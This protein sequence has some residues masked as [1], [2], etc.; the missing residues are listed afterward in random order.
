MGKPHRRV[1]P[2]IHDRMLHTEVAQLFRV[3]P[4]TVQRWAR[5]GRLPAI[6]TPGGQRVFSRAAVEKAYREAQ[7]G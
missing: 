1:M 5:N 6:E 4:R 7:G 3:D 2:P